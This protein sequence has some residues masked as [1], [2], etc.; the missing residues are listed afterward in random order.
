M[1]LFCTFIIH[2][3]ILTCFCTFMLHSQPLMRKERILRSKYHEKPIGRCLGKS[4]DHGCHNSSRICYKKQLAFNPVWFIK[5]RF[6]L[7]LWDFEWGLLWIVITFENTVMVNVPL[8]MHQWTHFFWNLFVF[9]DIH[10]MSVTEYPRRSW[11]CV[12]CTIGL[13]FKIWWL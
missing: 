7:M 2:A 6:H 8:E 3:S 10:N 12:L 1:L 9:N 13:L 5:H 11:S 4:S